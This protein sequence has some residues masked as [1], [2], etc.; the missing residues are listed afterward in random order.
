MSFA[1]T[2]AALICAI[3]ITCKIQGLRHPGPFPSS[4]PPKVSANG[5]SFSPRASTRSQLCSKECFFVKEY[6][7]FVFQLKYSPQVAYIEAWLTPSWLA[8]YKDSA[9]QHR[10]R[11]RNPRFTIGFYHQHEH[12]SWSRPRIFQATTNTMARS[13]QRRYEL[14]SRW[15]QNLQ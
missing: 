4:P 5:R 9:I 2:A 3:N 13:R 15:F 1:Q 8:K 12:D 14:R 11:K 6:S 7:Q 10:S